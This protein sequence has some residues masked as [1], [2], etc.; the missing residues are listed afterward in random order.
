MEESVH[1]NET[2]VAVRILY[3]SYE[4]D[5]GIDFVWDM[6]RVHAELVMRQ[7]LPSLGDLFTSK[8]ILGL[9]TTATVVSIMAAFAVYLAATSGRPMMALFQG[10]S[11]V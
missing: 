8:I 4:N 2:D 1:L 6:G 5:S 10:I 3:A 7:V 11:L 9:A